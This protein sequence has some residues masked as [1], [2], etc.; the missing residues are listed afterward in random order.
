MN[1]RND[2]LNL[3]A[4]SLN[5]LT[6]ILW[7]G[8]SVSIKLALAGIPP[9]CLAGIRFLLGGLVVLIWAKVL[10]ISLRLHPNERKGIAG[11][12][13]IFLTQIYLLNAGTAYT[14]ASRSTIFISAYP[15]FT[16]LFAHFFIPG[17]R[18][19]SSKILGMTLAFAGVI[20][21]F[22]ESLVLSDFQYLFGDVL[23]L[24]SGMLL[25]A[26]QIYLKHL[27]Q[28]MHPG[29]VL[30]WQATPSLPIFFALSFFFETQPIQVDMKILGGVLYQGLVVAGFCFILLTSLLQRYSASKLAVFGFITPVV[31][32]I[33]SNQLLGDPIS[34][35]ILLSL[36]L[37]GAGITIVNRNQ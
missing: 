29:K 32:V 15:F 11:L 18:I 33:I 19:N 13:L 35:G 4:G 7:G 30:I 25:G 6:A 3:R 34:P 1:V 24:C 26:R 23:V 2:H 20:S 16:A 10:G 9:L 28:N 8:N 31:G 21:V 36:I 12:V 37:V 17:D 27:T 5:L 22:A 14:L